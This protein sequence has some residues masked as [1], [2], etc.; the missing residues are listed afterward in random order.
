MKQD[1]IIQNYS[2]LKHN[3][4]NYSLLKH[5]LI[6]DYCKKGTQ[7]NHILYDLL[8]VTPFHTLHA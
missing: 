7:T 5:N 1:A 6:T 2:L 4:I 3:L 8:K